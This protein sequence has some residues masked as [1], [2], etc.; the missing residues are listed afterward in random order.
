MQAVKLL[1]SYA[2]FLEMVKN[3]PWTAAQYNA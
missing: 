2:N 3:D 1:R